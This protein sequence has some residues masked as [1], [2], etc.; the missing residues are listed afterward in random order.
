MPKKLM[1]DMF[2][3]HNDKE[4]RAIGDSLKYE[5]MQQANQPVVNDG[6]EDT[7]AIDTGVTGEEPAPT[8]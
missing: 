5:Q 3:G 6:S 1:Q 4:N 8:M 2:Q 7:T